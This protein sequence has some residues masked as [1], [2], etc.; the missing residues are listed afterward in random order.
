MLLALAGFL[1]VLGAEE[2]ELYQKAADQGNADAQVNLGLLY[3]KGKGVPKDLRKA[4]ELSQRAA[5]QG[6]AYAQFDLGVLYE[7][8]EMWPKDLGKAR[9][10][11]QKAADQGYRPAITKLQ[12][13]SRQ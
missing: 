11:Y 12:A 4:A 10:F 7:K 5:D 3:E 9:E 6:S 13:L 1:N 2:A 8:G